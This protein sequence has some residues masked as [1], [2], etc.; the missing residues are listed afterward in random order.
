MVGGAIRK[1]TVGNGVEGG[2]YLINME[3]HNR[4]KDKLHNHVKGKL[5]PESFQDNNHVT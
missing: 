5:F 4:V 3:A 1:T 2:G